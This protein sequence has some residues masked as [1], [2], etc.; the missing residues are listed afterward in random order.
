MVSTRLF[1]PP[2]SA[3]AQPERELEH[4][5]LADRKPDP[6]TERRLDRSRCVW[7]QG[8]PRALFLSVADFSVASAHSATPLAVVSA[9]EVAGMALEAIVVESPVRSTAVFATVEVIAV[10]LADTAFVAST[11]VVNRC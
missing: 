5:T 10:E 1:R 3:S 8:S 11:A 4:H 7:E 2:S 9:K 6:R